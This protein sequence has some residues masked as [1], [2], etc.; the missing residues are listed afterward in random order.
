MTSFN[1][2][3]FIREQ[4]HSIQEQTLTFNQLIICDDGSSDNTKEI[5]RDLQQQ[6]SRIHL[7]ENKENLGVYRN[8]EKALLFSKSEYIFLSD[9]DDIWFKDKLALHIEAYRNMPELAYLIN[10]ALM[11]EQYNKKDKVS[12]KNNLSTPFFSPDFVQGCC[13][14]IRKEVLEI[15]L[16]FPHIMGLT[17]DEWI[18]YV[19]EYCFIR[20]FIEEPL[21]Y[22]RRHENNESI[23]LFNE[24]S[25]NSKLKKLL[26]RISKS[27]NSKSILKRK[28]IFSEINKRKNSKRVESLKRL[29][30]ARYRVQNEKSLNVNSFLVYFK[31][32]KLRSI[33]YIFYDLIHKPYV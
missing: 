20:D 19:S 2:E 22:Y 8:F 26:Y 7:I 6:D 1:G 27:I 4:I 14:S 3:S 24:V 25:N 16:P 13:V 11:F 18:F 29:Y 5:I 17:H 12:K 23:S 28:E 10:D 15:L 21:Q 30:T 33:F 31:K 9:Q 32:Y